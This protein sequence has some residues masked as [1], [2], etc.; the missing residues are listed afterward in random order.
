[1]IKTYVTRILNQDGSVSVNDPK[2]IKAF[3]DNPDFPYLVSF[4]RTGSHWLRMIMELYFEKPSLSRIFYFNDATDFTCYHRHDMDLGLRRNN[5][6]YLYRDPVETVYSQLCYYKEEPDNL[7]R[8][9][10]WTNLYARHLS[11]WLIHDDFTKKKTVVT[12]EG[13]KADMHKEIEK[14]CAHIGADLDPVKLDSALAQVSREELKRKTKHDQQVINL[15]DSYRHERESFRNN[16]G[17]WVFDELYSIEP[18]LEKL[19]NRQ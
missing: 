18:A 3:T 7:E 13:M 10:H 15:T 16:Y 8:R 9:Q 6:I 14:V 19:F 2:I 5:V 4:S 17:D 12:Y 1:M 11:K